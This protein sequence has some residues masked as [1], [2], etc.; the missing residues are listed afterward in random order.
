MMRVTALLI[1]FC[2][3]IGLGLF[4]HWRQIP[5]QQ[6]PAGPGPAPSQQ[7]PGTVTQVQP[8]DSTPVPVGSFRLEPPTP[9]P[10]ALLPI[11]GSVVDE[12]DVPLEGVRIRLSASPRKPLTSYGDSLTGQLQGLISRDRWQESRSRETRTGADGHYRFEDLADDAF[13]SVS[14]AAP[15]LRFRY[16][17]ASPRRVLPGARI[18]FV[19]IPVQGIRVQVL[20]PDGS[21]PSD[22]RLTFASGG[23]NHFAQWSPDDPEVILEPGDFMLTAQAEPWYRSQPIAVHVERGRDV[24]PVTVALSEPTGIVVHVQGIASL[25]DRGRNFSVHC[26]SFQNAAQPV[27]SIIQLFGTL[28]S[29]S[30]R[31][32]AAMRIGKL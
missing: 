22:C 21:A 14:A 27:R 15:G 6:I 8:R 5:E 20:L 9:V 19:G 24:P 28:V 25:T 31:R 29:W 18:D 1:P 4:F 32:A 12:A 10:F 30:S 2:V 13:F 3:G 23:R 16:E 11:T 26:A 7:A 17:G